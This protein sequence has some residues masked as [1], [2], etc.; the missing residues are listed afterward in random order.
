MSAAGVVLS[1]HSMATSLLDDRRGEG[2]APTSQDDPLALPPAV[3]EVRL[4]AGGAGGARFAGFGLDDAPMDA[5]RDAAAGVAA[6]VGAS[7]V[8]VALRVGEAVAWDDVVRAHEALRDA[9]IARVGLGGA[10]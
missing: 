9:G 8:H 5:L 1:E 4:V 6:R 2:A 7:S 10:G 3:W